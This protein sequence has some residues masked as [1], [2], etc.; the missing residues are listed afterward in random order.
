MT[1]HSF[2]VMCDWMF[3]GVFQNIS[4]LCQALNIQFHTQHGFQEC[5]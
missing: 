4:G 3:I 5:S 2:A 1:Q